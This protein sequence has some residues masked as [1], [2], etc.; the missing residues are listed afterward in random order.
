MKNFRMLF[1]L[2][3]GFVSV[4]QANELHD[5][6]RANDVAK[7]KKLIKQGVSVHSLDAYGFTPLFRCKTKEAAQCLINKGANV[8]CACNDKDG[9]VVGWTALHDAIDGNLSSAYVSYL[10][11]CGAD[12][13]AKALCH[14]IT[15]SPLSMV[16]KHY[17][18]LANNK[19][20]ARLQ[21]TYPTLNLV[22]VNDTT[23]KDFFYSVVKSQALLEA[24]SE[25]RAWYTEV[26][27]IPGYMFEA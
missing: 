10:L 25:E 18:D 15:Y 5:A 12:V 3:L 4:A 14:G 9:S 26:E 11:D 16:F 27:L 8:N 6:A 17:Y 2:L 22:I 1:L 13:N 20:N 24:R 21:V 23:P 7:I 19:F